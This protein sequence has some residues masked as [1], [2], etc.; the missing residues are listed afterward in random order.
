MTQSKKAALAF[1]S[2]A[3]AEGLD[4]AGGFDEDHGEGF[5]L[6]TGVSVVAGRAWSWFGGA[7]AP[8]SEP[9]LVAATI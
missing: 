3:V 1:S 5:F 8:G 9:L 7:T 4:I 2:C 6:L